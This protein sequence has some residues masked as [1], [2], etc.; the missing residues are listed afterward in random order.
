MGN[1]TYLSA[2]SY[3]FWLETF[4]FSVTISSNETWKVLIARILYDLYFKSVLSHLL[5]IIYNAE[6][7]D[8]VMFLEQIKFNASKIVWLKTIFNLKKCFCGSLQQA[9]LLFPL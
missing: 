9:T 2:N 6:Y 5:L 1:L 7:L 4:H 8:L 3:Q